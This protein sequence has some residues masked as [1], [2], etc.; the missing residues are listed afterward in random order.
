[1]HSTG[2]STIYCAS[3]GLWLY[4]M[5]SPLVICLQEWYLRR[6][7]PLF[8]VSNPEKAARIVAL[9][10]TIVVVYLAQ[11]VIANQVQTLR[12]QMR[13]LAREAVRMLVSAQPTQEEQ[14]PTKDESQ[15]G[16]N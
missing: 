2:V 1:D 11:R 6:L 7:P 16:K 9:I 5:L 8:S 4:G 13:K 10:S 3:V 15:Q 14:K 12:K